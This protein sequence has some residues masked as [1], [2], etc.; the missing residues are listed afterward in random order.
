MNDMIGT[1]IQ[2]CKELVESD[3]NTVVQHE[4]SN[5][6][7]KA[8]KE[9]AEKLIEFGQ[10][11]PDEELYIDPEDPQYGRELEPH[12]TIKWG[13]ITN[14][15]DEVTG[16]IDP[17]VKPFTVKFGKVS[18]FSEEDKPYD[19]L[20]IEVESEEMKKLH[21][22]I[23]ELENEDSHPDYVP[24][25]TIAYVKKGEGE[26]Y[27]GKD[28]FEG[29]EMKV[30]AFEFKDQKGDSTQVLLTD[31]DKKIAEHICPK[32]KK[33]CD[34]W[35]RSDAWCMECN[36][37]NPTHD[38]KYMSKEEVAEWRKTHPEKDV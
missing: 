16:L 24:H 33:P 34:A 12:I 19:V 3:K 32:C 37:I 35:D 30:E 5:T 17:S 14:D 10:T 22:L 26:K 7:I 13:L 29:M 31:V 2:G 38:G 4:Y 25:M 9:I 21:E 28:P 36:R 1:I 18:M 6:Q 20:K 15:A 27:V 11:I 23:G 8:T